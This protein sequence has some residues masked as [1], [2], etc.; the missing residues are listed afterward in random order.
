MRPPAI[1]RFTL[2]LPQG[3]AQAAHALRVAT[4]APDLRL[5]LS[6]DDADRVFVRLTETPTEIELVR[7]RRLPQ[8]APRIAVRLRPSPAGSHGET[9]HDRAKVLV[10]P[11]LPFAILLALALP[12]A[13]GLVH[14]GLAGTFAPQQALSVAGIVAGLIGFLAQDYRAECAK[15]RAFLTSVLREGAA[16]SHARLIEDA[17]AAVRIESPAG[18]SLTARPRGDD[19][20]ELLSLPR[21]SPGLARGDLVRATVD[22]PGGEPRIVEILQAGGRSTGTLGLAPEIALE[23][24]LELLGA[25]SALGIAWERLSTR[26]YALDFPPEVADGSAA[27]DAVVELLARR[28]AEGMVVEYSVGRTG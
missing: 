6:G 21:R 5:D 8:K 1:L 20:Y 4:S 19:R 22:R 16:D 25:L 3:S 12:L 17:T 26:A 18:E 24:E 28:R 7:L 14:A 15:A 11:D 23:D 27:R 10:H 9:C 2:D 13:I